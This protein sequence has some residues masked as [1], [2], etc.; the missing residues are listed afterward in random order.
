MAALLHE[1]LSHW[2]QQTPDHIAFRCGNQSLTYAQLDDRSA[3]LASVL[4]ELDVR[5]GDRVAVRLPTGIESPIAVYAAMKAGAAMV[6]VDPLAPP[7]RLIEILRSGQIRHLVTTK[8]ADPY[9]ETINRSDHPLQHVIGTEP[10][11]PAD[12]P[13]AEFTAWSAIDSADRIEPL[14]MRSTDPAYV[15][16]TSGSTGI[17]KGIVHSHYSGNSYARLSVRTYA[18][19]AADRIANLSPLH[20]D[21]STFGYFSSIFAGA[22]TVLVPPTY[23]MLPASLSALIQSQQ[24]TI[25]YSV[26]FALV[27]LLERG[28]PEQRDLSSIRWIMYGGEPLSPRHAQQLRR[29]MPDAWISN[30]YGP[31]EVNQCT[32]FHIPPTNRGGPQDLPEQPI[33][34]GQLWDETDAVILDPLDQP[35]Q[36]A[37][38][39]ELLVHSS[40]MMTR[41]WHLSCDDPVT[42]YFDLDSG[43][44]FYRTGDLVRRREDGLLDFLGRVDRQVK[45]RGYRIE[46][47]EVEHAI[48]QL[49]GVIESAAF[50]VKA[51][52]TQ[53]LLAAV[54]LADPTEFD[55]A[56]LKRELS[57]RLPAYA[58]P[59]QM[60]VRKSFPRTT[61]GKIDRRRLVMEYESSPG[62]R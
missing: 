39:G 45:V 5:P 10:T 4:R 31:A 33:P 61:S 44:R 53:R 22:T 54:T 48:S 23:S 59:D 21:M 29:L 56:V 32:Y 43:K 13:T 19:T 7:G 12:Y 9:A 46:L 11:A 14:P 52:E 17:P 60:L 34:I 8:L 25:W 58:V 2:A 49:A 47:D 6:P 36:G 3:R 42:F 35:V 30:V 24:I 51:D 40:T 16:F 20:F 41:Y 62:A 50:C 27:Q 55:T 28:V 26:P 18:V 15:I 37:G 1:N 38:V 57:T